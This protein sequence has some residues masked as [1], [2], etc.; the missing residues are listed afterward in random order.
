MA[1]VS[2][3]GSWSS[4]GEVIGARSLAHR[5]WPQRLNFTLRQLGRDVV[6]ILE[7]I[8]R[9]HCDTELENP[10]LT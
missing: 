9:L 6:C 8:F 4:R 7:G 1:A 10:G 5:A 3:R 2:V